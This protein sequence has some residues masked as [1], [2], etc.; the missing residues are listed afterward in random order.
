MENIDR[1]PGMD[2]TEKTQ[3]VAEAKCL[4]AARYFDMFRHY[5]GLPLLYASFTGTESGYEIPRATVEDTVNYM[6]KMLDEPSIP[7]D[8]CGLILMPILLARPDT[9]QRPVL[10]H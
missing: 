6:I 5:G 10:W 8:W 2:D 4:I 3:L 9:G 1:V 7:V